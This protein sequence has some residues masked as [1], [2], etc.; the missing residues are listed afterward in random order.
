MNSLVSKINFVCSFVNQHDLHIFGITESWLLKSMP[1]SFVSLPGF[2]LFRSDTPGNHPK[3]GVCLYVKKNISVVEVAVDCHN[4]LCLKLLDYEVFIILV[5]RPPSNSMADNQLLFNVLNEFCFGREVVLFGD[6]NFPLI[7]WSLEA[8]SLSVYDC[9]ADQFVELVSS[10]GLSQWITEPTFLSGN[11]LD[12][13]FTSTTDRVGHV[14]IHPP[15]PRC[16][17]SPIVFSYVFFSQP[18][19]IY[20]PSPRYDWK[21]GRYK[22]IDRE[23]S[24]V[25]WEF[26]FAELS[27]SAKYGRL[28]SFVETLITKYVPQHKDD[29]PKKA[30]LPPKAMIRERKMKWQSFKTIRRQRGRNSAEC[31]EALSIYRE[32][33]LSYKNFHLNY[34]SD[35]ELNLTS[36]LTD[37]SKMFHSY[38]RRKKVGAPTI[39]P[40]RRPDG[41]VTDNNCEMAA[42]M[43]KEFSSVFSVGIFTSEY[44]QYFDGILITV[45]ISKDKLEKII[46]KI[47]DDS[48]MG[49]DN[50]HPRLLKNCPSLVGPLY[51]IFVESLRFARVPSQWKLSNIIPIFKKGSRTDALNYRPISLT[52]ICC[53]LLERIITDEIYN[54]LEENNL[55]SPHQFGFRKGSTV[56]DQLLL[57]YNDFSKWYKDGSIVDLVLFDFRKAFDV[58]PHSILLKKLRLIGIGGRLLDWIGD[59]L[60]GREMHVSVS[61]SRSSVFPVLSGVPQGSV[62]GPLLFLIYVNSLP[63]YLRNQCKIFADDL[64]IYMNIRRESVLQSTADYDSFQSDIDAVI[65]VAG[66]WGLNL[67]V[68]KCVVMRFCRGRS[69]WISEL[70]QRQYNINGE[71]LPFVETAR[72]LGV[73]IDNKLKFHNHVRMVVG[74]ASSLC[75]NILKTTV[76]RK[77]EF[78]MPLFIAHVRPILE[79][80]SCVWSTGYVGDSKLLEGVQRRWTKKIE[81][82][83]EFSYENRLRYLNLYSVKGRMLRA[84]IIKY[85]KIFH[86]ESKITPE[87]VFVRPSS[88]V[89]RG[90]RYKLDHI[91][92]SAECRKRFFSIRRTSTWNSLPDDLVSVQTLALFKQGLHNSPLGSFL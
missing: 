23:I 65:S 36:L 25:D 7:D 2:K 89:T 92:V 75:S 68:S 88:R 16:G 11:V 57:A 91:R 56:D 43:A 82:L 74:K 51:L 42:I 63:Q 34:Q 20:C 61:G 28:Q 5:Y 26:E 15:F 76:C 4:V 86:S 39:G 47:D 55:F 18:Y 14:E 38:I 31:L 3:H 32:V 83:A 21:R 78:L 66:S 87:D 90:H 69:G 85:W 37:N 79:F 54:Y 84:D 30:V 59:F 48:S 46:C 80:A 10:L 49:P 29:R 1:D 70:D 22:H 9:L 58:V 64:K 8:P 72:D 27:T 73:M 24:A 53:K 41:T 40:L 81:G 6:F 12:L 77:K 50:F 62:L 45:I 60:N 17:H 33:N 35:L 44:N 52:S 67:N 19:S 71:C 13:L